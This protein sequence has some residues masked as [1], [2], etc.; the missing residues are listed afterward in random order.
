M[1]LPLGVGASI[2]LVARVVAVLQR[3]ATLHTAETSR[4]QSDLGKRRCRMQMVP[5]PRQQASHSLVCATTSGGGVIQADVRLAGSQC[6]C[7]STGCAEEEGAVVA[8]AAAAA[9]YNDR[10][11]EK[12]PVPS[13]LEEASLLRTTAAVACRVGDRGA[14]VLG[15]IQ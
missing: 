12:V 3:G 15:G 2:S 1:V 7:S 5:R 10:H 4:C 14:D 8:G 13:S 11:G 9:S 6:G